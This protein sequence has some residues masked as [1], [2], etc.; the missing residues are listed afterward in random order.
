MAQKKLA[1]EPDLE[2][3]EATRCYLKHELPPYNYV[4]SQGLSPEPRTLQSL[5][6][7]FVDQ[8]TK[9]ISDFELPFFA[10]SSVKCHHVGTP[11][12]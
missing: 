10:L 7:F 5:L 2:N 3:Q 8:G 1:R 12:T 11:I 6:R 4:V 9:F